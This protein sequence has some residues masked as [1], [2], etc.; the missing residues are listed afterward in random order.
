M[1]ELA[2]A[3]GLDP[4]EL[5]VRNEPEVDPE[6]GKPFNDRRLVECLR[7]GAERFGWAGRPAEPGATLDGDWWVGTGVAVGD[8]PRDED[9]GQRRAGPL[10]RRRPLR[11]GDRR[12]RHRHRRPH[13]AHPDRRR[14]ARGRARRD[15]PRRSPTPGLPAASVA[16]GSSGTSSWGTAIVAAAQRFR[17]DHGDVPGRGRR[18]DRVGGRRPGRR[19][20]RLPLLRRGLRRGPGAPLDRRDPGAAAARRLL[21]RP[22]H[23]PDDRALAAPRRTGDGAVGG[24]VRGVGPRPALRPRRHPGPRDLPRRLARRR[25]RRRRRVA[26][27][28]RRGVHADGLARASA[29]SGS[30]A[31]PRRS[32][33]RRSTPP[34]C[35]SARSR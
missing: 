6:T 4:I 8:V 14:R 28:G 17:A 13:R 2:V 7:R 15:R 3:C 23:Q 25:A 21:G 31:P 5:R 18:D 10:A 9:A 33:T 26:G 27:G 11:R 22:G 20:V 35:G 19:G 24:A 1:D 12:R 29:R 16:G 30:S 34:G 32:P